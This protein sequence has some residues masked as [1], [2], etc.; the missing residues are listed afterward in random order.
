MTDSKRTDAEQ[1]LA[2]A[3]FLLDCAETSP[4]TRDRLLR[5]AVFLTR[6]AAALLLEPEFPALPDAFWRL[7]DRD[8]A[9][10]AAAQLSQSHVCQWQSHTRRCLQPTPYPRNP[11]GRNSK[12]IIASSPRSPK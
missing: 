8:R 12:S 3:D 4:D 11:G 6:L 1:M 10:K 5:H 2:L 7:L 9:R